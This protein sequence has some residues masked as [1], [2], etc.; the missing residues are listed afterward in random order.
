MGC[1]QQ[2]VPKGMDLGNPQALLYAPRTHLL[3]HVPPQ[4]TLQTAPTHSRASYCATRSPEA[5]PKPSPSP[6]QAQPKPVRH[7]ALPEHARAHAV[8][9]SRACV[10]NGLGH[11]VLPPNPNPNPDPNPNPKP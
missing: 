5:R 8:A 3:T 1:I 2:G 7:V 4:P 6:A 9:R 11:G 10:R